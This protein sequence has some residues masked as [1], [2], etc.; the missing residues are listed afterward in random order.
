MT[1]TVENP[2]T[3]TI[4]YSIR[5]QL[6]GGWAGIGYNA[7]S[8]QDDVEM[9]VFWGTSACQVVYS[10]RKSVRHAQPVPD[11]SA[12]S[13]T[14]AGSTLTSGK[15]K[16]INLLRN[17]PDLAEYV[18]II[19]AYHNVKPTSQTNATAP[20]PAHD[21]SRRGAILLRPNLIE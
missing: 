7:T 3:R 16:T 10:V 1:A 4:K 9:H 18:P 19:W 5:F 17:V 11:S 2:E 8:M 12:S 6:F 13:M 14:F 15:I 21:A 20:L